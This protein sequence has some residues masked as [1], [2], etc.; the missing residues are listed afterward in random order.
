MLIKNYFMLLKNPAALFRPQKKHIYTNTSR[1]WLVPDKKTCHLLQFEKSISRNKACG[2][3]WVYSR[4]KWGTSPSHSDFCLPWKRPLWTWPR[5]SIS[6]ENCHSH[7]IPLKLD[8]R[9]INHQQSSCTSPFNFSLCP[10]MRA[11]M[12]KATSYV[13]VMKYIGAQECVCTFQ[14]CGLFLALTLPLKP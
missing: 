10:V 9:A 7:S 13:L 8:A 6:A 12:W 4:W 2:L 5:L 3:H 1:L 14:G 11:L